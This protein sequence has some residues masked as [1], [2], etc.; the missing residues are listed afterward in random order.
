MATTHK[1]SI[2]DFDEPDYALI[3]IHTPLEDY[4]LAFVLNRSLGLNLALN[5]TGVTMK[6][7]KGEAFFS[8]FTYWDNDDFVWELLQNIAEISLQPVE[9]DLFGAKAAGST[10][11]YL[12]PEFK[13]VDYLIKID[14]MIDADQI[15]E[16][17]TELDQVATAYIIE[18]ELVKSRNNLIL[19][20]HAN[21][22]KDEDRSDAWAGL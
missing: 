14:A 22:Q 5:S 4:R 11:T 6:T 18:N 12:L 20:E 13:K 1:L 19:L 7:P 10:R 3:A 8:R 17:L 16:V 21:S 2:D 15:V 9:E